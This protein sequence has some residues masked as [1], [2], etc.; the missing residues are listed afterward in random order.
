MV[1]LQKSAPIMVVGSIGY[2]GLTAG[3][4]AESKERKF[5]L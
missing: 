5:N 3:A 1:R 4:V 2:N